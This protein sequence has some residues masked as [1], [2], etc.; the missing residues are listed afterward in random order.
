MAPNDL[1]IKLLDP[2]LTRFPKGKIL[3][4]GVYMNINILVKKVC[5]SYLKGQVIPKLTN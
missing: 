3:Q 1:S 5:P 4:R 2:R